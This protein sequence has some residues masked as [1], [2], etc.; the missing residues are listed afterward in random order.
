MRR[1]FTF[2][3]ALGVVISVFGAALAVQPAWADSVGQQEQQVKDVV[4]EIN[5]QN[6][7]IDQYNEAYLGALNDKA[8]VEAD[9]AVSQQHIA[10]QQ[11]ELGVLQGQLASVAVEQF[12]GGGSGALG[13][14]FADPAAIDDGLQREHLATVAVNAGAASSDDYEALLSDLAKE[15]KTLESKQQHAANLAVAADANKAK[16]EKGAAD[17]QAQ[18][19]TDKAKLGDLIQQEQL[20]QDQAAQAAY[21]QQQSDAQAAA[22]ATAA[23]AAATA[24]ATSA[25]TAAKANT[26]GAKAP[27]SSGS[28][29]LRP[30]VTQKRH[31]ASSSVL[32]AG[33]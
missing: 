16:A 12:M 3:F 33:H 8:A 28:S 27:G 10:A 9:I 21:A 19:V 18:L 24:A 30:Q 13:P 14:L 32:H 23:K 4:A 17:L 11:A 31:V 25:A 20:R 29:A 15:E 22:A 7:N 2:P 6:Q 1:L 5:R 26:T